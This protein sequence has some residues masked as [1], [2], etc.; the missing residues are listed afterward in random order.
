MTD[1]GSHLPTETWGGDV[2][3]RV[4]NLLECMQSILQLTRG[5]SSPPAA[6]VAGQQQLASSGTAVVPHPGPPKHPNSG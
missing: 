5:S 1:S 6:A 3:W 2:W 4:L